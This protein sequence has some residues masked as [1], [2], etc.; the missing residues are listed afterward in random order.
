MMDAGCL[1]PP[2]P[3]YDEDEERQSF[4]L[5]RRSRSNSIAAGAIARLKNLPEIKL[6]LPPDETT[7]GPDMQMEDSQNHVAS[8]EEKDLE[9]S[10]T[11]LLL[12]PNHSSSR[13][14]LL[15]NKPLEQLNS[16]NS[17]NQRTFCTN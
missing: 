8:D 2:D 14:L 7:S 17:V 3:Y 16:L 1:S 6:S 13:M 15:K 9:H 11:S 4:L 10:N 5:K 12:A